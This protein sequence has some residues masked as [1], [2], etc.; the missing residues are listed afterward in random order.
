MRFT[1]ILLCV[2]AM[3][4]TSCVSKKKFTEMEDKA[5]KLTTNLEEANR[6][7]E[8]LE[9]E[10]ETLTATYEEEKTKLNGEIS[11]LKNEVSSAQAATQAAESKAQ[12]AEATATSLNTAINN[13][14]NAY[15]ST[16]LSL[17]EENDA[18]YLDVEAVDFKSGSTRLSS[19][20]K[21]V[22]DSLAT[23]LAANPE[24]EI[25]A[26]GHTDDDG[27]LGARYRDN[28]DLSYRRADAAVRYLIKAG[29]NPAQLSSKAN[30]EY[31]PV[32]DNE[33]AE[34]KAANRRV[35][36]RIAPKLGGI[37][38]AAKGSK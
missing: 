35:V 7:I 15:E 10:K 29:V 31:T 36:F 16:N 3:A 4:T 6:N 17:R 21:A 22:L 26:E 13:A 33:T 20:D 9:E 12:T 8:S 24:L 14:F 11:S 38:D 25:T 5:N 27:V 34:G 32:G 23:V 30:G 28:W 18:I 19:S 37:I 2:V 1:F